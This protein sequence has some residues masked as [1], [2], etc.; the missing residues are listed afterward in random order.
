MT[1]GVNLPVQA[2][3]ISK[4]GTYQDN[5]EFLKIIKGS[6]MANAIGRAGRATQ[7]TE[8]CVVLVHLL[9]DFDLG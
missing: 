5:Q 7:E 8:G 2:V 6:K 3:I 4:V 9:F 1:E